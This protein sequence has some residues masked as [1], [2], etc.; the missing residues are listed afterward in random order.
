MRQADSDAGKKSSES[1][2][3]TDVS[4]K[5]MRQPIQADTETHCSLAR[6]QA[7]CLQAETASTHAPWPH[8]TVMPNS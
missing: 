5:S 2:A 8:D 6:C 4:S 7:S 1:S 3:G